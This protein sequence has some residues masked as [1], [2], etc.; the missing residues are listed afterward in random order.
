MEELDLNSMSTRTKKRI[1]KKV[2]IIFLLFIFMFLVLSIFYTKNRNDDVK[3]HE[4]GNVDY[5]VNLSE[6]EFFEDSTLPSNNQYIASIIDTIN[7]NFKYSAKMEQD[8]TNYSYKYRIEANTNVIEKTTKNNI[9]DF[10]TILKEEEVVKVNENKFAIDSSV[11]IDYK[12]YDSL[13][14]K[15]VS[16]YNLD[17]ADCKTTVKLYVDLLDENN[18]VKNGTTMAVNI[19]LNV[20]TVNIDVENNTDNNEE[21]IFIL[22]QEHKNTWY[23]MAIAVL[24]LIVNIYN[25]K[26]LVID[27]KRNCPQSIAYD[28][29]LREILRRYRPYI[30]KVNNEFDLNKYNLM[31]LDSFNDM[32]EIREITQNPI[33][34]LEN[35]DGTHI[36]FFITTLT[37]IVYVYELNR[38]DIKAIGA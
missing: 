8:I 36:F 11:A 15:L 10:N 32:L 2:V 17:N 20:K 12:K 3:Y 28:M 30:Q 27:L 4:N 7:V 26:N 34:M 33:L 23:L 37:E 13:I 9:Y 14:K 21:K 18:N 29:K 16:T 24:L 35:E 5:T 25:I 31:R 6:N 22:G 1:A 38:N 19:P